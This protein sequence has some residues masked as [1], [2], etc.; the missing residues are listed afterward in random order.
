MRYNFFLPANIE[1]LISSK[2]NRDLYNNQ[3]VQFEEGKVDELG[4]STLLKLIRKHKKVLEQ[5][6]FIRQ[7]K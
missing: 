4:I 7:M 5:E 2:G 6:V 1:Q 3:Q